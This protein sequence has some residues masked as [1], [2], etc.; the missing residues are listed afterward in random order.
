MEALTTT[1]CLTIDVSESTVDKTQREKLDSAV[2]MEM[3]EPEKS[4]LM[5]QEDKEDESNSLPLL[6]LCDL[7]KEEAQ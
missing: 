2:G 6:H 3:K 4:E 7:A 1:D 5:K